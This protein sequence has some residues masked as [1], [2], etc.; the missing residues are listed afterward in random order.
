MRAA[1]FEALF[2]SALV[3][4]EGA[5][6]THERVGLRLVF[7]DGPGVLESAADLGDRESECCSFFTFEVAHADGRVVFDVSVGSRYADVLRGLERH[8]LTALAQRGLS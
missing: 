5:A 7:D 6:P 2:A 1:E 3:G 4:V 8:A